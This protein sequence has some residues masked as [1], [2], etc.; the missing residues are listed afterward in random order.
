M[1]GLDELHYGGGGDID[2]QAFAGIE[3]ALDTMPKNGVILMVTDSGTKQRDL[4]ASIKKKSKEKNIKIFISFSPEC[5]HQRS[6]IHSMPSYDSVSEGRVF[7]KTDLNS[8]KFFKS[9]V[10]TVKNPCAGKEVTSVIDIEKCEDIININ[11]I[12]D[13]DDI[14][15]QCEYWKHKRGKQ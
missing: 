11:D 4:E 10:Y 2:E 13:K 14:K 12:T 3:L 8:E 5:R 6:C 15:N 7:N 1:G 9:V